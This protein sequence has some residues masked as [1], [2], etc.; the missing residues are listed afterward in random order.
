MRRLVFLLAVVALVAGCGDDKPS[1]DEYRSTASAICK[2]ARAAL[3]T[4]KPPTRT[5]SAAIADYFGRLLLVNRETLDRFEKL[6]APGELAAAHKQALD[7]NRDGVEEVDKLVKGLK[8]GGD[9]RKLL[10]DAQTAIADISLRSRQAAVKL[11]V[12][13]CARQE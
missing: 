10:A 2:Q 1:A 5:T 12:P 4:V 7:A 3:G 9:P 11:G 6:E 13:E 8:A